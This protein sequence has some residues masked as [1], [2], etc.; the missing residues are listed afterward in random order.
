M[1]NLTVEADWEAFLLR[2][3]EVLDSSL[4]TWG[5]LS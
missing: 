3:K 2:V 4:C 5:R 1:K